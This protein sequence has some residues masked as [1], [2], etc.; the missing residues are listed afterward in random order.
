MFRQLFPERKK[1]LIGHISLI[2][3]MKVRGNII[4]SKLDFLS[5]E[6]KLEI[7]FSTHKQ[8]LWM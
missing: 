7:F 1:S 5:I 8:L 2:I 6:S 3:N 4:T